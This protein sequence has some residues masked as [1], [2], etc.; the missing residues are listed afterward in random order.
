MKTKWN[1]RAT[2]IEAEG[3]K[4]RVLDDNGVQVL[5]DG[6]TVYDSNAAKPVE[7]EEESALEESDLCKELTRLLNRHSAEN[8]S[9]TPDFVLARYLMMVLEAH[10][11]ATKRRERWYGVKHAPGGGVHTVGAG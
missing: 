9:N 6:V 5:V 1:A 10:T 8:L 4:I 3:H 2:N 7:R 11:W